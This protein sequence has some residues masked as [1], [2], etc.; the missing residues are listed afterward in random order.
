MVLPVAIATL[1]MLKSA[2][3][4]IALLLLLLNCCP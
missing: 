2:A 4:L 3:T 1:Y